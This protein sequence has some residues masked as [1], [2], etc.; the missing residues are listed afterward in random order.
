[1]TS[2][3]RPPILTFYLQAVSVSSSPFIWLTFAELAEVGLK[4]LQDSFFV[5]RLPGPVRRQDELRLPARERSG[6]D[7]GVKYLPKALGKW[8][9]GGILFLQHGPWQ[10]PFIMGALP[11]RT[12]LSVTVNISVCL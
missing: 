2:T 11:A 6:M 9:Q 4:S 8:L 3:K 12:L 7:S 5:G 1:M 10:L